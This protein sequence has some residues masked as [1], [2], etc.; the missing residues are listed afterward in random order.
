[1]KTRILLV[2]D[3]QVVREGLR[4]VLRQQPDFEIIGEAGNGR[5]AL[6][7]VGALLPDLIVM[8][9]HMDDR[10]GLEISEEI[11]RDHPETK[12]VIL[13]A[14]PDDDLV[15]RAVEVGVHGYLLKSNAMEELVRAIRAALKGKTYLSADVA[16]AMVSEHRR[17]LSARRE[18]PPAELSDRERDLLRLVAL[19]KRNKEVAAELGLT[20]K[21]IETYRSH[22]MKK[23]GCGSPAE[24]VRY[25][26][27]KGI[28]EP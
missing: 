12:I 4:Y 21:S 16:T 27:R 14:Y 3:H 10:S 6:E 18:S 13:S 11:L 19:G 5:S 26:I 15:N 17:L 25:A 22:L 1:M 24:L 8:D 23:L 7:Q 9:I 20:V 28:V 2:D